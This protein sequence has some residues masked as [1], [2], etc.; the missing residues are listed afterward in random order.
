MAAHASGF[1]HRD[2]RPSKI[3]LDDSNNA[4]ICG[5]ARADNAIGDALLERAKTST[6]GFTLTAEQAHYLVPEHCY[7]LDE[8]DIEEQSDQYMLGLLAYEVLTRQYPATLRNSYEDVMEGEL[9]LFQQLPP[10]HQLVPGC[11]HSLSAVI[12]KMVSISPR[13]RY[14]HLPDALDAIRSLLPVTLTFAR[15]SY[16]RCIEAAGEEQEFF[17]Y[18]YEVFR[19]RCPAAGQMFRRFTK[20]KW[21]R[22]YRLLQEGILLLLAYARTPAA[23]Q[24]EPNVLTR[25]AQEHG[26]E[27]LGVGRNWLD[28][29]RRH[30]RRNGL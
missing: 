22:Q 30:A 7:P 20:S 28:D 1:H 3:I 2:L 17:R 23:A 29:F 9:P 14:A 11:P 5:V 25:I 21:A 13:D 16:R 6:K 12:E 26:D 8:S 4:F 10:L 18:F 19:E 24:R 27:G 15:E